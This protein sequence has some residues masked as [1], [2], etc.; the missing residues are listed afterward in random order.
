MQNLFNDQRVTCVQRVMLLQWFTFVILL[1]ITL[2]RILMTGFLEMEH[3]VQY[4][5]KV[6]IKYQGS[7]HFHPLFCQMP[8]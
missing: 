4:G 3:C 8:V 7:C 5:K 1:T 6:F 2:N